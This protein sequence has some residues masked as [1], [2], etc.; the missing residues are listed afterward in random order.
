MSDPIQR[1]PLTGLENAPLPDYAR[2]KN[3]TY[4]LTDEEML[5]LRKYAAGLLPDKPGRMALKSLID[6]MYLDLCKRGFF[7]CAAVEKTQ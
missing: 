2:P 7:V 4:K 3:F 6:K 1:T 5:A